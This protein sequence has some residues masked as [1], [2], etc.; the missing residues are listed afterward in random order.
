MNLKQV[1]SQHAVDG[2]V[3][4]GDYAVQKGRMCISV[5]S[6]NDQPHFLLADGDTIVL[7]SFDAEKCKDA[8]R[9]GPVD[10][11]G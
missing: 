9:R 1:I 8:A 11:F 3:P 2:W 7:G 10:L 4:A 6:V 5:A